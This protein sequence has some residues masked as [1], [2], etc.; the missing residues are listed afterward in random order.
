MNVLI[1]HAGLF[2][3]GANEIVLAYQVIMTMGCAAS[4]LALSQNSPSFRIRFEAFLT[5]FS[6]LYLCR[7]V[8]KS[9]WE[10]FHWK[11]SEALSI[12]MNSGGISKPL[13]SFLC[14]SFFFLANSKH[15]LRRNV[16]IRDTGTTTWGMSMTPKMNDTLEYDFV[17]VLLEPIVHHCVPTWMPGHTRSIYIRVH[18]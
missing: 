9:S 8:N 6:S 7:W 5:K 1:E 15:I 4:F 2:S 10:W 18:V 16:A 3:S 12:D 13:I 14:F 11:Q 17:I